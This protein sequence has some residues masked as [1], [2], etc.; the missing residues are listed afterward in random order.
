[1]AKGGATGKTGVLFLHSQEGFGAD[2]AIHAHIM[3]YL[4]RDRFVVHVACSRGD[5]SK[6]PT[7]LKKLREIPDLRVRPTQFAPGFRQRSLKTILGQ[8]RAAAGFPL[9]FVR[10]REYVAS[11]G[12]RII[13]GSDRPRDATYAVA[14]GKATG[15]K[16]IVHVHVA[17]S[18]GY[19]AP[20]KWAVRSADAVFAISRF[21]AETVVATG[22]RRDKVHTVLNGI[23][24]SRWTP[25]LDGSSIRRELGIPIDAPL[26]GTVS[27]LFGYKGHRDVLRAMVRVR[28][29]VP[30]VRWLV[31]GSDAVEVHGGSFTA[32]LKVLAHELGVADRI[33]F[34]GERSDIP[35][36][37]AAFDVFTL[38]SPLEPFG[39]VFA[40]AMA[41]ERPVVAIGDGGTVEVVEHGRSGLLVPARDIDGLAES[42]ITLLKDPGLRARMGASGRARVLSSFTAQR[43][44]RDAGEAY[45]AVLRT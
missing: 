28:E 23:D 4:D 26:I 37:M 11:E 29:A 41:M 25:G 30:E 9:D 36:I 8:F 16:S 27:R 12:I 10:L 5:G 44:A 17:W 19:S 32:E 20:A 34:A 6:E 15:A 21:V 45:D 2:S 1:M 24:A 3:R 13:H 14:L 7:S 43:M 35:Q 38:P 40:E 42:L 18:E 31:V 33:L 39:L 22:T